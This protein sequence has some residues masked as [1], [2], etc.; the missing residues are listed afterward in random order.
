MSV[1]K[2]C[3]RDVSESVSPQHTLVILVHSDAHA[4]WTEWHVLSKPTC[5]KL[6]VPAYMHARRA[7]HPYAHVTDCPCSAGGYI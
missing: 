7:V 6:R 2:K 1:A 5:M 4:Q 3:V